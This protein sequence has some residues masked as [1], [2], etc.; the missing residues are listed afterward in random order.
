MRRMRLKLLVFGVYLMSLVPFFVATAR[1]AE[2]TFTSVELKNLINKLESEYTRPLKVED[3][4][5]Q[6]PR[7]FL[8]DSALVLKS[9]SLQGAS[10]THP[11]AVLF[12]SGDKT[13]RLALAYNGHANQ[14]RNNTIE[15]IEFNG[16][17]FDFFEIRFPL[18]NDPK[19][20]VIFSKKNPGVCLNC[21]TTN[22]PI[23]DVYPLWSGTYG[24][25]E[26]RIYNQELDSFKQFLQSYEDNPRYK[27]IFSLELTKSNLIRKPHMAEYDGSGRLGAKL[28]GFNFKRIAHS[29]VTQNGYNT[30]KFVLVASLL[31]CQ[32]FTS[33]LRSDEKI[34]R[35]KD[36]YDNL[37]KE[38][39]EE[40][41]SYLE[42]RGHARDFSHFLNQYHYP[43]RIAKLKFLANEM[44]TTVAGW[45]M[46]ENGEKLILTHGE[47]AFSFGATRAETEDYAND[48]WPFV[49]ISAL[50]DADAS[51]AKYDLSKSNSKT[52]DQLCFELKQEMPVGSERS[53][54]PM[55]NQKA[56]NP[57]SH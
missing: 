41:Q 56:E 31:G 10:P 53:V 13:S 42:K 26:S 38:S 48:A 30:L 28:S 54:P 21:H 36:R 22:R 46:V 7:L 27:P 9:D 1:G 34:S 51:L 33:Y 47:F 29:L 18:E 25:H 16:T 50:A 14:K 23:W 39:K 32:D 15:A 6:L 24:A 44:G 19:K 52:K 43:D 57:K 17:S 35:Y 55:T 37:L 49:F 2:E 11:R 8:S 4:V 3:I 12:G 20:K 40:Y 5:Q 45:S